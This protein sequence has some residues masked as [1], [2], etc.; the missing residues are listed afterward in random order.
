MQHPR[1]AKKSGF[2]P[3]VATIPAALLLF[4]VVAL[5][6]SAP[7]VA[8]PLQ[9]VKALPLDGVP[10]STGGRF[11]E[12]ISVAVNEPGGAPGDGDI[13]VLDTNRVQ[14]FDADGNFI[15]M[16]GADVALPAA[17]SSAEAEWERC[18]VADQCKAGVA[19]E[20]AGELATWLFGADIKLDQADGAVWVSDTFNNRVVKFDADGD[21]LFGIGWDVNPSDPSTGFELCTA[22]T[23]CKAGTSGGNAGQL[24]EPGPLAVD[25]RNGDLI[26]ANGG[27]ITRFNADG[28]FDKIYGWNVLPGGPGGLETC[29]STAVGACQTAEA[30]TGSDPGTP[31][32]KFVNSINS[33][34]VDSQ[35]NVYASE[36]SYRL[37]RVH[38]FNPE[39]T[40]AVE[41]APEHLTG[42]PLGG[43][44]TGKVDRLPLSVAIDPLTDRL[45]VLRQR[46]VVD[47]KSQAV[48][49]VWSEIAE[50][51]SAQQLVET[52]AVI[53]GQ[54]ASTDVVAAT[55]TGRLL[56]A[57]RDL[58]VEPTV[59]KVLFVDVPVP[60]SAVALAPTA[61]E[62]TSATLRGSVDMTGLTG[63][64]RFEYRRQDSSVW[65]QTPLTA[66]P[67]GIGSLP[68]ETPVSGMQPGASYEYKLVAIKDYGGGM[69][70]SDAVSFSTDPAPPRVVSASAFQVGPDAVRLTGEI[71]PQGGAT[72]YRFEYGTAPC[73][74]GGCAAV[75]VP[76][77]SAGSASAPTTVAHLVSGLNGGV[78]Y[79]F[80]LVA[81]NPI[82]TE[83]G[84]ERIFRLGVAPPAAPDRAYEQVSPVE[85]NG[86]DIG[87]A[88]VTEQTVPAAIAADGSSAAFS[89]T[90]PIADIGI[91]CS[92]RCDYRSIRT[93]SGW[94]TTAIT[95]RPDAVDTTTY[96]TYPNRF[97]VDL[98]KVIL[99]SNKFLSSAELGSTPAFYL[100]D[101]ATGAWSRI[102]GFVSPEG[103]D[104]TVE[105]SDR[106][107]TVAYQSAAV[108]TGEGQPASGMKIYALRDGS[109]E[110]VSRLP[111]GSFPSGGARLGHFVES[112]VGGTST[113]SV[114]DDGA[115]VF[116]STPAGFPDGLL[117]G[118]SQIYRRDVVNNTTQLVSPSKRTLPQSNAYKVFEYATP[119]GE[120]VYFKSP[121]KLTDDS[122]ATGGISGT[123]DLYRYHV[124]SDTLVD[125]SFDRDGDDPNG[126]KVTALVAASKNGDW[127]Y[128]VAQGE[129]VDGGVPG[130]NNLYMWH[131]DGTPGGETRYVTTLS[132]VDFENW[133]NTPAGSAGYRTAQVSDSGR[134][135]FQS[136]ADLT[137]HDDE[138]TQVYLYDTHVEGGQLLCV[139]CRPDGENATRSARVP[140][141]L[142]DN[143]TAPERGGFAP[144]VGGD[145]IRVI[146]KDGH[147]AFFETS[148]SLVAQDINGKIDVYEWRDG[149]VSLI[150]TGTDSVHN[151]FMGASE[152]GDDVFFRSRQKLV[153][154]DGDTL[155]DLYDARVGGGFDISKVPPCAGEECRP[156]PQD[157]PVV[158][159]PAS[160]FFA[161]G[162]NVSEP[163]VARKPRRCPKGKRKIVRKGKVR[164][165][166][167]KTRN[168]R[169][170]SRSARRNA[171]GQR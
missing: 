150:S 17:A 154:T 96:T 27:R 59:F 108:L 37:S 132:A 47:P 61:V 69:D 46:V 129:V 156:E 71:D 121:Q 102:A 77:G 90:I 72:T 114:S 82:G 139:S 84:E 20:D 70:V 14:Q 162:G 5:L 19:G 113:N 67:A 44:V 116:F 87:T 125:L 142:Q 151:E 83:E 144:L 97:S 41:F 86:G 28:S 141:T 23:G 146:S 32:G 79:R 8:A 107:E 100:G 49:S 39:G 148:E 168:A 31:P 155:F 126:S 51:N 157:R 127:A 42:I 160:G 123:L 81:T 6:M 120:T 76:D 128:Y 94:T 92:T 18:T 152:S 104:L 89:A 136:T 137:H 25:P 48:T 166:K 138:V 118:G 15:R 140:T 57:K 119:D 164:C 54:V 98:T 171:G 134:L 122:T 111:D 109:L 40:A 9:V 124:P 105:T 24:S 115:Y 62:Q 22:A 159:V 2:R 91:G 149:E 131:D 12:V 130:Q 4:A 112:P 85:K 158:D 117:N 21:F 167:R 53:P 169:Q 73:A 56:I 3:K 65:K 110:L 147:R 101:L 170:R 10:G 88:A 74:T 135:L 1:K 58:G 52:H 133:T 163:P 36:S 34:A 26:V 78:T 11:Q 16:W 38:R 29:T 145:L 99:S 33:V 153:P 106:F 103:V 30:A 35:G 93:H 63:R 55:G 75:P 50:V 143:P 7:A 68:V 161:G 13:Y 165:V 66:A 95:P 80:R 43:G 60:P 45:F 64:Y